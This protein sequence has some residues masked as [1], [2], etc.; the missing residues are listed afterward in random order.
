MTEGGETT[1]LCIICGFQRG[2]QISNPMFWRVFPPLIT[3][4]K[5][6]VFSEG[7]LGTLCIKASLTY[8]L[9]KS[10][11]QLTNENNL[12]LNKRKNSFLEKKSLKINTKFRISSEHTSTLS[13]SYHWPLSLQPLNPP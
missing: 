6:S 8:F 13:N 1:V 10:Q 12:E 4:L 5:R 11:L 9:F 2:N 3:T 7:D